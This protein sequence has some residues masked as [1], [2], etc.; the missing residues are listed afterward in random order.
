MKKIVKML[1]LVM[2]VMMAVA[3]M[4]GCQP[5]KPSSTPTGGDTNKVT[6]TWYDG[7]TVL[8]EEKV[9]KGTKVQS[10]DP[11]V[12]GKTFTGWFKEA[13]KTEAFDFETVIN[14]DTDI[15]AAFRTNEFVADEKEY[16]LIGSGAG[17]MGQSNWDHA[18]SQE[19]LKLEKDTA[20]TD[21]NVYTIQITMYAGDRFQICYGGEWNG[22]QGI[23]HIPGAAYA[24]GINPNDNTQYTAAD[25][26]YAEVKDK[27]GNVVFIGGDEYNKE[28]YV[29]NIIL[30]EGRDGVYKFTLTTYPSDASYN[31]I[32]WE[33]VEAVEP[34]QDTHKMHLVGSMNAWN[35]DD[36]KA[37]FNME[38]SEDG[39]TWLGYVTVTEG[40][41]YQE[42]DKTLPG[43]ALKVVNQIG[44]SWHGVDGDKNLVLT[45]PG[46]YAIRYTVE[47]NV[48]ESQKL[49]YYLV[50]TF[51]D[52]D[53]KAV[54]FSVKAGVT[55]ELTV[56]DGIATV[57][58]T[59][60]DVTGVADYSWM[61]E[62][63]KP[64]VMAIKV[65]YGCEYGIR[66]WFSDDANNGDNFY[67][68]A[69]EY[70]ISLDIA[71]EADKV[72]VTKN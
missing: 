16:Y 70:T 41:T 2:A 56:A 60:T 36:D 13:S 33:L 40:M 52:A 18:A 23:G 45:E 51:V 19:K 15:F 64:G 66:D 43:V 61:K 53:G 69:G 71:A 26:K 55:P 12:E 63:N 28:Y 35:P 42:E 7:S 4:A 31:T 32:E 68:E 22:Q 54:N 57:T 44:G 30:A 37:E 25:K 58:I 72:T 6:V 62:Q 24:D 27:D 3:V 34:L 14:E 48:V 11:Q 46:V 59:A 29:W 5:D 65:V 10:W 9:D 47:G 67:L 20:V 1:A 8:K 39:K 49:S 38:K 21:K 50:G 17:D